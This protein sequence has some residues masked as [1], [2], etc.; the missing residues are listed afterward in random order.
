MD[1]A[2]SHRFLFYT[3][4]LEPSSRSVELDG[5]EFHHLSRVLRMS[6]G[7][8]A[9]A[10]NGRGALARCRVEDLA[11]N[12]AR[13]AVLEI[14][15]GAPPERAVTLALALLRK[16][17][18]ERAVEQCTELGI[19]CCIPFISERSYLRTYSSDF[20]TRLRR[21]ALSAMKQSF[22]TLLPE[23]EDVAV[24]D[25]IAERVG[26]ASAAIMGDG[27][28]GPLE[29]ALSR[30]SLLIVIGPEGGLSETERARLGRAGCRPVRVSEN[31]LRSETAAA[32]LVAL[33][34]SKSDPAR[35]PS[36]D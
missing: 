16:D 4:D 1:E 12:R 13:L 9:Y 17:A 20:M 33:A 14:D 30:G 6:P 10:T 2:R 8:T 32:A 35:N 23:V 21:I 19:A 25:A 26:E 31:R 18:F 34:L 28:G 7:E 24:F 5:D 22:R 29:G 11:K 36:V 15:P 27:D 3:P